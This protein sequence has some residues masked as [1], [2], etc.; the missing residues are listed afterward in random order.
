MGLTAQAQK[1]KQVNYEVK[2]MGNRATVVF[3]DSKEGKLF[4]YST[5]ISLHWNGELESIYGFV[6][7]MK[8]RKVFTREL[9]IQAARFIHIVCD[10]FDGD[11]TEPIT[12]LSVRSEV[13]LPARPYMSD[14]GDNGVWFVEGNSDQVTYY[15]LVN[16]NNPQF[17]FL[18]N[19][20][21]RIQ[22]EGIFLSDTNGLFYA[23]PVEEHR[24]EEAK[25]GPVHTMADF[26]KRL[27]P[28]IQCEFG[29]PLR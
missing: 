20:K 2:V 24:L 11:G 6:E 21:K 7:E 10:Y 8:R 25:N 3:I 23:A 18:A 26:Y 19:A 17:D 5:A 12:P 22:A 27:R 15:S 14:G 4:D 28:S 16:L 13:F 1:H 29:S 9:D